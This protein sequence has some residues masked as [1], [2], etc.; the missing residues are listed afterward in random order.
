VNSALL[1]EAAGKEHGIP[2]TLIPAPRKLSTSCGYAAE[3][4]AEEPERLERLL[5]EAN[6]EWEAIWLPQDNGFKA[7]TRNG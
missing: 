6:I 1:L 2:C 5:R 7:L 3:I 4:P